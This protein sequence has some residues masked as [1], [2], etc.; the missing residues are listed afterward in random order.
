MCRQ[1]IYVKVYTDVFIKIKIEKNNN[2]KRK[3]N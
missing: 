1:F 2:L 3:K